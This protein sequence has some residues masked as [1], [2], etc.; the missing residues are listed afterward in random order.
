MVELDPVI[1]N[2]ARDYFGFDEDKYL[3]VVCWEPIG[4]ISGWPEF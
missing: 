4:D 2:I 3:K 1:L